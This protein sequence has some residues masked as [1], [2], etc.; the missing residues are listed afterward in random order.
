[1]EQHL[2]KPGLFNKIILQHLESI[3]CEKQF[4]FVQ[5][6]GVVT[7]HLIT[8]NEG[9]GSTAGPE[10]A[11]HMCSCPSVKCGCSQHML[12]RGA[13][14]QC[15]HSPSRSA[16][17]QCIFSAKVFDSLTRN[18]SNSA[19]HFP[20]SGCMSH[21]PD[22]EAELSPQA[23]TLCLHAGHPM[24]LT[25]SSP[26]FAPRLLR[27]RTPPSETPHT[28]GCTAAYT[29]SLASR[30]L[31]EHPRVHQAK[32]KP[33]RRLGCPLQPAAPCGASPTARVSLAPN[34]RFIRKKPHVDTRR[35]WERCNSLQ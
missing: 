8:D 31:R 9:K 24:V 26:E 35:S 19:L 13:T 2:F 5:R 16:R 18:T 25:V 29:P 17:V 34:M 27:P 32:H 22:S 10:R 7:S 15:Q 3:T 20:S 4:Y 33:V 28:D 11:S 6:S 21:P 30:L 23:Q 14:A 12:V 1:L